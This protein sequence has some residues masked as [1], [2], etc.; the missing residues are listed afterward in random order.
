MQRVISN[1]GTTIA[2]ERLGQGPAIVLVCGASQDRSGNASLAALLLGDQRR[3]KAEYSHRS[4][5]GA[6][7]T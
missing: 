5:A 6:S 7:S 4:L 2:F 1:D 3:W